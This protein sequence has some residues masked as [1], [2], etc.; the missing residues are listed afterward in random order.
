MM[1]CGETRRVAL[2][3][4]KRRPRMFSCFWMCISIWRDRLGSKGVAVAQGTRGGDFLAVLP[5]ASGHSH[6]SS[7]RGYG[8]VRYIWGHHAWWRVMMQSAFLTVQYSTVLY[9]LTKIAH[10]VQYST[11]NSR[12]YQ[13]STVRSGKKREGSPPSRQLKLY[14]TYRM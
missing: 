2:E 1:R 5:G 9:V 3:T 6:S 4:K 12:L 14:C 13:Y 8:G 7:A 11:V 10:T